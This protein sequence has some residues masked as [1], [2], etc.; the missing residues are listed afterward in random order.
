MNLW[1]LRP[2]EGLPDSSSPWVPW[3]DCVFGFVVRAKTEQAARELT[4]GRTGS[5]QGW[6]DNDPN[7]WENP[8]LS[9]CVTLARLG[10]PG[11]IIVDAAKA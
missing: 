11:V 5:E 2:A 3:C 9:T 4:R 8:A 6:G 7:P 10:D 1:I